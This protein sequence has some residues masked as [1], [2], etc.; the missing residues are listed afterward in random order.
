MERQWYVY[1]LSLFFLSGTA[2]T[3]LLWGVYPAANSVI[4]IDGLSPVA[5]L[6][7]P[8]F[9]RASGRIFFFWVR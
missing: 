9:L 7:G 8:L 6:W 1:T 5:S 2:V 3:S 4:S